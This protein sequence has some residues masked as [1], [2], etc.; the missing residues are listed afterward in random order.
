MYKNVV[1]PW[2][3]PA[4]TRIGEYIND[5]TLLLKATASFYLGFE[6]GFL[7][8]R[9]RT[10]FPNHPDDHM[11]ININRL[12]S[13]LL[14]TALTVIMESDADGYIAK[15]LDLPVYGY[16]DDHDEAM[17]NLKKEIESLYDDLVEDDN[18][19]D[20]WLKIKMI[21]EDRIAN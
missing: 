16:G 2:D 11:T 8:G 20:E 12:T 4:P 6:A 9:R 19:T 10:T 17:D 5:Y 1:L 7:F 13:R 14:K 21:L 15:T 18:L 3:G